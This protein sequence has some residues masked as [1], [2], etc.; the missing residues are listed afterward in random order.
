M[1]PDLVRKRSLTT[2]REYGL[3]LYNILG[4][5][6]LLSSMHYPAS[7]ID[8]NRLDSICLYLRIERLLYAKEILMMI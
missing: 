2:A 8:C 3:S 7:A 5:A 4:N 1:P 6:R